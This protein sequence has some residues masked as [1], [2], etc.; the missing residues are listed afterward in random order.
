M[1]RFG[2]GLLLLVFLL[3]ATYF[4]G[5]RPHFPPVDRNPVSWQ[6]P[7]EELDTYL[8]QQ[9]QAIATLKPGNAAHIEWAD[10]LIRQTEY[11]L[12]YLHGFSAGPEESAPLHRE[13]AARYGANL[14]LHRLPGHG[15]A[16]PDAFATLRPDELVNSAKEAI[17]IGKVIGKKVIL[18]SCSTGSTLSAYLAPTDPAI[19]GQIMY[20][21]NF[22]LG[23]RAAPLLA[24][25]WAKQLATAIYGGIYR[26]W[27]GPEGV[28]DFWTTRYRVEGLLCLQDLLRQTMTDQHFREIKQ[29]YLIGYYYRD[30]EHYDDV[31]SQPRIKEFAALSATPAH[32]KRVVAFPHVN[33]HVLGSGLWSEDLE[34]VRTETQRFLEEILGLSPVAS[35]AQ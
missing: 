28:N 18:M 14:Y 10:S 33:A 21:P 5:P 16:D 23:S 7:L 11:A 29:P 6:I 26:E 20:S 25:P 13:L 32:Q 8:D 30:K 2:Y 27:P 15:L 9:E 1:C 34:A 35:P 3:A 19:V 22:A 4:L 17:A 12:V 31:I 24:G